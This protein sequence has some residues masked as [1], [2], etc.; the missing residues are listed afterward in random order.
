MINTELRLY[1]NVP[2]NADNLNFLDNFTD[3]ASKTSYFESYKIKQ[4][5][6]HQQIRR[7]QG[8][9]IVDG[10]IQDIEICN[11]LSFK[12]GNGRR[13]FCYV[14]D[15]VFQADECV[16]LH[17]EID[18]MTT[19]YDKLDFTRISHI[20]REHTPTDNIGEHRLD[21]NLDIGILDIVSRETVS[22]LE[23]IK[24]IAGSTVDFQTLLDIQ[25]QI[26]SFL[27]AGLAYYAF[28]TDAYINAII[29][30]LQQAGKADAIKVMF[31]FPTNL[32]A[33]IDPTTQRI[34]SPG[35]VSLTESFT[36]NLINLNGYIPKNKKLF[37]YPYN[38]FTIDN[39]QGAVIDYRYENFSGVDCDFTIQGNIDPNPTIYMTPLNYNGVT[40]NHSELITLNNYPQCS[41]ITDIYSNWLAQ[42]Q[43]SNALGVAGS[44]IA[45]ASGIATANPIAIS[46]GV[47]GVAG[48]IGKFKEM[49]ILPN[50]LKGSTSGGG[51]LA[52]GIQNYTVYKKCLKEEYAIM[53]D[54]YFTKYGYK[55]S[56]LKA[57]DTKSRP[58]FNYVKTNECNLM[59]AI[60]SKDLN[61]IRKMFNNGVTFWHTKDVGN[62]NLPNTP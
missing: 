27:Y 21:E 55:V 59:G 37:V 41:W 54:A 57:I 11:Y 15:V 16:S 14:T 22:Q 29:D 7:D 62:Y 20:E 45:L 49:S 43:V 31:T 60:P 42:N 51:N 56:A 50:P 35:G 26:T 3:E 17:F 8:E 12:N 10:E 23:N 46:S 33:D 58:S 52:V 34:D 61:E 47:L 5:D 1:S 18:Y 19:W 6:D 28:D 13:Y 39:N 40:I 36:K 24:F 30:L 53:I 38:F 32:I 9:L 48:Q 25:G 2:L 44:G 4:F